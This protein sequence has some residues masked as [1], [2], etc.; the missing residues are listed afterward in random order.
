MLNALRPGMATIPNAMLLCASS[1]YA[2]RGALYDAYRRH[3]GIDG[4]PVLV[5]RAPTRDMNPTVPQRVIDE[6]LER[7]SASAA[8]EYFAEFR[9]DIESWVSREAVEGCVVAGLRERAPVGYEYRAFVDPSGGSADSFTL[10]I[11]HVAD[12]VVVIDAVR[13]A[14]PPFSPESVVAEFSGL[15]KSFGI[16]A[17]I[18]DRYAGEW[19]REAFRKFGISYELSSRSKSDLYR[20]FLPLINSGRVE[21][22]DHPRSIAQ[23]CSLERRTARGGRDSI[24]HPP[25]QHDDSANAI[26]GVAVHLGGAIDSA[27]LDWIMGPDPPAGLSPRAVTIAEKADYARMQLWGRIMADS[28]GR[29]Y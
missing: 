11:G 13:E 26:A 7:D 23:L 27:N 18:G 14:A 21:L 15:L 16:V 6:A 28:G 25:G 29:C 22:L 20:D 3:H 19:P 9:T 24:E 12:Q 1:P 2:R 5:W 4:D 10:C 17:V 8:A